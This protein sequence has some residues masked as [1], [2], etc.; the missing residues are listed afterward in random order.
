MKLNGKFILKD[1]G[2][3]YYAE[4]CIYNQ[5][6][7]TISIIMEYIS[8]AFASIGLTILTIPSKLR[9]NKDME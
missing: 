8:I 1:I 2:G 5:I 3:T 7:V 6:N 9:K 4:E